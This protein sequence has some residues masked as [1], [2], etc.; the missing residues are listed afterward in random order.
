MKSQKEQRNGM[1]NCENSLAATLSGR[2]HDLVT[3]G[4]HGN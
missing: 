1:R 2:A 3:A 4:V